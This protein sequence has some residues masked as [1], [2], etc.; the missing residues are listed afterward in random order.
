MGR[1]ERENKIYKKKRAECLWDQY[2]LPA[3]GNTWS[4]FLN[5]KDNSEHLVID[6]M[7]VK[8]LLENYWSSVLS[9]HNHNWLETKF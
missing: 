1:R 4:I 3:G 8:N 2:S 9:G 6:L 7:L 5:S